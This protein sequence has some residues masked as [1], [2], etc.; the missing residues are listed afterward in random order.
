MPEN[1]HNHRSGRTND[2]QLVLDG[3]VK[4]TSYGEMIVFSL[5]L[6]LFEVVFLANIPPE[7]QETT[8]IY[9]KFK[10]RKPSFRNVEHTNQTRADREDVRE[11]N[12]E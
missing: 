4:E 9:A 8:K 3:V 2:P 11:D 1:I 5:P 10:I 6:A 7:G 12:D